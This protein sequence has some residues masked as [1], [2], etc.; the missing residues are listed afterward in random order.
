MWEAIRKHPR[1]TL[2]GSLTF[3]GWLFTQPQFGQLLPR[4][5]S[6]SIMIIGILATGWLAH[7][8]N[9]KNARP[10]DTLSQNW[11]PGARSILLAMG[12]AVLSVSL[13]GCGNPKTAIPKAPQTRQDVA[14]SGVV[15]AANIYT[16]LTFISDLIEQLNHGT[17]Q[18]LSDE[19]ALK[20]YKTL[21]RV[22]AYT[23][24]FKN[25]A[26]RFGTV[27][28]QDA[29]TLKAF[30]ESA[31]KELATLESLEFKDPAKRRDFLEFVRTAREGYQTYQTILQIFGKTEL[32]TEQLGIPQLQ[33]LDAALPNQI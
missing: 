15:A 5:W 3:I 1:T 12:I 29:P 25:A 18:V 11:K 27:N 4:S 9:K 20:G 24:D 6:E 28:A 13:L 2:S 22:G 21:R 10:G 30:I 14:K 17:P 19:Q 16:G 23:K 31:L 8:G 33:K 7:D 32:T 26:I